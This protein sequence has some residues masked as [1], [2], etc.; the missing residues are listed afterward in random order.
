MLHHM[1]LLL[2]TEDEAPEEQSEQSLD[3]LMA[4][5]KQL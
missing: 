2:Q 1:C 4:Q 5:M 3:D